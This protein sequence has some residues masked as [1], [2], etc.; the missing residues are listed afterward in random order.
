MLHSSFVMLIRVAAGF[1][2]VVEADEVSLDIGIGIGDTVAHACL[3][4]KVDY[5][6]GL[7]LSKELVDELAVG[8]VAFDKAEA[9]VLLELCQAFFFEAYVVVVV[10]VVDANYFCSCHLLVDGRSRLLPMKLAA[11]V[12]SIFMSYLPLYIS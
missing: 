2:D 5:N 1:E 9:G 7:E 11:P 8:Y 4:S 12:T 10:H 3:C 6:L